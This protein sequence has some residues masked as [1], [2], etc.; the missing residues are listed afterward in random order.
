MLK[1]FSSKTRLKV[2]TSGK[3][4]QSKN[5]RFGVRIRILIVWKIG[6]RVM[7][8]E[9][10]QFSKWNTS[11][12]PNAISTIEMLGM[13]L[14]LLSGESVERKTNI[15]SASETEFSIDS[16]K[17]VEYWHNSI[18]KLKNQNNDRLPVFYWALIWP[19]QNC[20]LGIT[21]KINIFVIC[22]RIRWS[23]FRKKCH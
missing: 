14:S 18:I 10:C 9:Y 1:I 8:F 7:I 22:I 5:V 6:R 19:L 15:K 17:H 16:K 2:S 20:R 21:W 13:K 12:T 23:D 4:F 3:Q 11:V